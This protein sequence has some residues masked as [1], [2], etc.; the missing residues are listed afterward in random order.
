MGLTNGRLVECVKVSHLGG[1]PNATQP[2]RRHEGFHQRRKLEEPIKCQWDNESKKET[3]TKA[4]DSEFSKHGY[5]EKNLN[6]LEKKY[7]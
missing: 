4:H 1:P 5:K 7:W 2:G 6:L 3:H